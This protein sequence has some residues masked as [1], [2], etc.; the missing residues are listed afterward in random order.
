M[1]AEGLCHGVADNG[2]HLRVFCSVCFAVHLLCLFAAAALC[3]LLVLCG[4][5]N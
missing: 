2:W 3:F 1:G 5:T 4:N